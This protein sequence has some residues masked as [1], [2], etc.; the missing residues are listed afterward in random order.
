MAAYCYVE[1]Q[2]DPDTLAD[3]AKRRLRSKIPELTEAFVGR[4]NSHH[5]FMVRIHLN[6][7]DE[8][9]LAIDEVTTQIEVAINPFCSVRELLV[10]IPGISTGVAE[11]IIAETGADMTRFP[12]AGHLASW[13]GTCPGSNESA[14]RVKS[15]RSRPGNL[16][17]KNALGVAALAGSRSKDT[18][19][20][21]RYRRFAS[22][23]GPIKAVVAIEHSILIAIWHMLQTGTTDNDPGK[24]YYAKRDLDRAKKRALD[25]LRNL[26]YTVTIEPILEAV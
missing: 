17:L 12:T 3:L 8:H 13:A 15:T 6:L 19:L 21:A 5:A 22:R 1:G 10:T 25:Q 20:Q 24:D 23:R 11:V 14:C 16:Y 18:Y 2:R 26:G 4:F 9:T 7:I